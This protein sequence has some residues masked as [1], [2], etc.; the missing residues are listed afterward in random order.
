MNELVDANGNKMK[1]A[2][3][4]ARGITVP[5]PSARHV[6]ELGT[7]LSLVHKNIQESSVKQIL[8]EAL[9]E[10]GAALHRYQR[11]GGVIPSLEEEMQ[12]VSNLSPDKILD[13]DT[14]I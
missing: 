4:G 11:D 6:V 10:L 8:G 13:L 1:S 14:Q 5:F 9:D 7:A 2:R 3:S 12:L